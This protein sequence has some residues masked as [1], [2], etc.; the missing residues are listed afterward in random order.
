MPHY[1]CYNKGVEWFNK[2]S[3][4]ETKSESLIYDLYH[5]ELLLQQYHLGIHAKKELYEILVKLKV[6]EDEK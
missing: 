2:M 4:K 3:Q 5:V 1:D 6:I